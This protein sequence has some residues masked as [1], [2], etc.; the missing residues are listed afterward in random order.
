MNL[1][2]PGALSDLG[3]LVLGDGRQH[4]PQQHPLRRRIVRR[5]DKDDVRT[6]AG[7]LFL[8]QHLVGELAA[9]PVGGPG[10]HRVHFPA[11]HRI[12]Q[13]LQCRPVERGPAETIVGEHV[14]PG[15]HPAPV[16]RIPQHRLTL[17]GDRLAFALDPTRHPQIRRHRSRCWPQRFH[18]HVLLLRPTRCVP[19]PTARTLRRG[20]VRRAGR[21]LGRAGCASSDAMV[22]GTE[23]PSAPARPA[24]PGCGPCVAPVPEVARPA[25][26][27][28]AR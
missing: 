25:A 13:R 17:T 4:L 2:P 22:P 15:H 11:R 20:A 10:H 24:N 7:E 6:V 19:E 1:A 27:G 21:T 5:L 16:A 3:A 28:C 8:E 18:A 23:M 12:A 26:A 9:E 14:C